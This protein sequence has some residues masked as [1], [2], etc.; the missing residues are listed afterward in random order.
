MTRHSRGSHV[1]VKLS[2]LDGLGHFGLPS[3]R[4]TVEWRGRVFDEVLL[5][6]NRAVVLRIFGPARFL[7]SPVPKLWKS[8]QSE[9][10]KHA[11]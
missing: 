3:I 5:K 6:R 11:L 1:R 9:A 2:V 4:V 10:P 7:Y 8:G